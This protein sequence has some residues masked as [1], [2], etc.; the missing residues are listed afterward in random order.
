MSDSVQELKAKVCNVI[1]LRADEIIGIAKHVLENPETGYR[2]HRTSRYIQQQFDSLGLPHKDDLALTGVK[3]WIDGGY[4]G[5][6]VA[7]IGELDSLIVHD[8]PEHDSST[9]AAHACAHHAQLGMLLGA[10]MGITRS[11][12]IEKLSG[13]VVFFAVPAEELIEVEYR[14]G[15]RLSGKV[16]FIGGKPELVRLGHFDDVDIAM[17]THTTG[18]PRD[19]KMALAGTNNGLVVKRIR[20]IG[21]GAHAGGAPHL[22]INALNAA[23]LGI[24][25]IHFLRE[26]FREDDT[27]RI[28]PIITRG[29]DAVSAVPADV[30][31]ET[32]VRA[33]S[34]E[35]VEIWEKRVDRALRA[36]AMAIGAGVQITTIPGYLPLNNNANMAELYRANAAALVGVDNVGHTGHRTSSTDMGDLSHIIP[37]IQPYAG[38]ASGVAHGSDFLVHDYGLAVIAPAKVMAMTVVDLLAN[39]AAKA[40]EIKATARLPMTKESYLSRVRGF[41]RE[42]EWAHES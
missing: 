3:A 11:G 22:G 28:H 30:R 15:L 6:T 2:E 1:D 18:N 38:G 4:P 20:Y 33:K 26:T 25:G 34:I 40:K 32:F 9:G 37:A 13:R 7:V 35:A 19:G 23:L 16:E 14:D 29:G 24:Q 42:E 39:A 41:L 17:M 36:G 8:H 10:A 5:P 31:L 21:R 27:V 12:V